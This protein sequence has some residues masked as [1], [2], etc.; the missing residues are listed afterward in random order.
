M[1]FNERKRQTFEFFATRQWVRVPVYPVTVGMYP[2]RSSC[3]YL[4]KL[5]KYHYLRRGHD[6]RGRIV[7]HLSTS[8][9]RWLLRNA[10]NSGLSKSV[11]AASV[12]QAAHGCEL[13]VDSVRG[14]TPPFHVHAVAHD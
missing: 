2:I 12:R 10:A 9:A 14:Q 4:K 7:Y 1:V 13:L 5:H 11:A 6:F 8:G 3:R